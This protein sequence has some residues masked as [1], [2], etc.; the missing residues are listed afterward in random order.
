MAKTSLRTDTLTVAVAGNPNSGKTT[1]FNALTGAR[2]HVGNYP[3]VTVE[4]KRGTVRRGELAL[5]LVD[6][7]GTYSLTP[8]SEEELVARDYLINVRPDV[9]VDVVDAAN[10]ERHLYL[11]TELLEIGLP[12][13]LVLNMSDVARSRGLVIDTDRLS[14]R[15]GVPVVTAVGNR[16][17]GMDEIVAAVAEVAALQVHLP[18]PGKVFTATVGVDSNDQT[19]GG[20]GSVVFIVRVAGK[21]AMKSEVIREGMPPLPVRVDL[22]RLGRGVGRIGLPSGAS[23]FTPGAMRK[24]GK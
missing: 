6:L 3:G 10:L 23:T 5:D 7:P 24:L 20:R 8:F 11:T 16:G 9:V 15:L 21:E 17:L 12:L 22:R 2:Q 19:S 13:V 14:R 1:I 18:G 4:W